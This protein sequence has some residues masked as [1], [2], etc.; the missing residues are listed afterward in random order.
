MPRG[1]SRLYA[2]AP[3]L[4]VFWLAESWPPLGSGCS[5]RC[6][7]NLSVIGLYRQNPS[8]TYLLPETHVQV[9]LDLVAPSRPVQPGIRVARLERVKKRLAR[10]WPGKTSR[11]ARDRVWIRKRGTRLP[12]CRMPAGACIGRPDGSARA[13]VSGKYSRART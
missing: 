7:G 13:W 11:S 10:Y 1:F 2:V 12:V 3:K 5:S 9:M 8:T 4:P 6:A